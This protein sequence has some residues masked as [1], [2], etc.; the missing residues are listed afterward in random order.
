MSH[1]PTVGE[2][3]EEDKIRYVFR[4]FNTDETDVE[5]YLKHSTET[6]LPAI[7]ATDVED[8]ELDET[9]FLAHITQKKT[10]FR[11][12]L[13]SMYED[14]VQIQADPTLQDVLAHEKKGDADDKVAERIE[15][16]ARFLY[17]A[18]DVIGM[19]A[20]IAAAAHAPHTLLSGKDRF[21]NSVSSLGGYVD[22]VAMMAIGLRQLK[23]GKPEGSV[24]IAAGAGLT[25]CTIA[26]NVL[27]G[28]GTAG[29][30]VAAGLLGF[31]YTGALLMLASMEGGKTLLARRRRKRAEKKIDESM[32]EMEKLTVLLDTKQREVNEQDKLME[33]LEEKITLEEE[34]AGD[35]KGLIALYKQKEALEK[36]AE[37]EIIDLE[38]KVDAL[39]GASEKEKSQAVAIIHIKQ[40]MAKKKKSFKKELSALDD[41]IKVQALDTPSKKKIAG[42]YT[43]KI[44]CE[45]AKLKLKEESLDI[46]EK[47]KRCEEDI[48]KGVNERFRQMAKEK[49]HG[50]AAKGW[51]AAGV[52]MAAVATVS[53]LTLSGLTF[54]AL[55]AATIVIAAVAVGVGLMRNHWASRESF[56]T[57]LDESKA[58]NLLEQRKLL[59]KHSCGIDLDK[60]VPVRQ[61]MLAKVGDT[62]LSRKS[63]M[64]LQEY[65]DNLIINDPRKAKKVMDAYQNDDSCALEKAL[66]QKRSDPLKG[67]EKEIYRGFIDKPELG[68]TI[69]KIYSTQSVAEEGIKGGL[70]AVKAH[71]EERKGDRFGLLRRLGNKIYNKTGIK[72]F[73]STGLGGAELALYQMIEENPARAS[74]LMTDYT[75]HNPEGDITDLAASVAKLPSESDETTGAH[76]YGALHREAMVN[77]ETDYAEDHLIAETPM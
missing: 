70:D 9:E 54:G 20:A 31:S 58:F 75:K 17:I 55:P 77:A 38:S 39:L 40:D 42:F 33:S 34:L 59:P 66:R 18:C 30:T 32:D 15:A 57:N 2:L 71:L 41:E 11:E 26:S 46:N 50:R 64:N 35:A 48:D 27:S 45:E 8:T 4:F 43:E 62:L 53:F 49:D 29:G 56:K 14:I 44:Q 7:E 47:I 37:E 1:V 21:S 23:E 6:L 74:V 67:K 61:G 60:T 10:E 76:L 3:S 24:S 65:I 51:G 63:Q 5:A 52:A 73:R 12:H 72:K 13:L 25:G 68:K 22:G 16:A 69:A 28:V 19:A 36:R